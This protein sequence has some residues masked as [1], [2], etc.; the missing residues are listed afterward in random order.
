ME[1][2]KSYANKTINTA[3]GSI[4]LDPK[5]LKIQENTCADINVA[6]RKLEIFTF[7]PLIST[8]AEGLTS[9]MEENIVKFFNKMGPGSA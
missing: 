3:N 4:I 1:I 7:S 5:M 8:I 9:L 2:T 6:F